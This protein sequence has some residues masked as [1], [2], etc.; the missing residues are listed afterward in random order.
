MNTWV[1]NATEYA[2]TGNV[3]LC[4]KCKRT[5]FDYHGIFFSEKGHNVRRKDKADCSD[6]KHKSR[7]NFYGEKKRIFYSPVFGRSVIETAYRLESLAESDN[8]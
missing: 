3:G 1:D 8:G 6:N 7:A 5:Y 2:K 4:P